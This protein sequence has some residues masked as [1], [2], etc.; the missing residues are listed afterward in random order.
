MF[1]F[2]RSSSV[3]FVQGALV[4]AT[5]SLG[6]RVVG[7]LRDRVLASQFGAG[8][9]LDI[10]YAAFRIPDMFYALIVAGALSGSFIPIFLRYWR[11]G[12]ENTEAWRFT[13]TILHVLGG[14][15]AALSLI[16]M[17][18]A[19]HLVSFVAPGFSL[20]KQEQVAEFMRVLYLAQMLLCLSAVFGNVLQ[21]T[22]RFFLF[23]FA[24]I[25]YNVGIIVGALVFVRWV[26]ALGL[27]L[28]VVFGALQH[29]GVTW[30]GATHVGYRRVEGARFNADT[31][32]VL[33]H[34]FPR[35]AAIG[36]AQLQTW[37]LMVLASL[38]ATGSVAVFSLA[39]NI[40]SFPVG[41]IGISYGVAVFPFLSIQADGHD[42]DAFRRTI[43]QSVRH[44]LF[45]LI[46]ATLV[47]LLLRA[48]IVR[49]LLGAGTFDWTETILVADT[50][51]FFAIGFVGQSLVYVLVRGFFAFRDSLTPLI[52]G[53]VS[54]LVLW[55]SA[56]ALAPTYGVLGLSMPFTIA[57][58]IQSALLWATLRIRVGHLE[59]S[60]IVSDLGKM[61]IA[62]FVS[63]LVMQMSKPLTLLL[64]SLET[65]WG[66]FL[67]ATFVSAIGIAV[68]LVLCFFLRVPEVSE[69]LNSLQRCL[70]SRFKPT[71]SPQETV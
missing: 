20:F 48:Q 40:Q 2:F 1:R 8:E 39:Y 34:F 59:E 30:I 38:L 61:T 53:V 4:L 45:V 49:I 29:L 16:G 18:F 63:A 10:Y 37:S 60:S 55:L 11:E 7:L 35:L 43:S 13:H 15:L 69:L 44:M 6:S 17:I 5:L 32:E 71:E 24:P 62:G 31:K 12:G 68:Y 50:L 52:A 21:A 28:G 41:I 66:V 54:L 70:L 64:A 27:A 67:Q 25:L 56:R 57:V 47:F 36:M 26:G 65:F 58:L 9:T 19:G 33:V 3:S 22:R 23:A 51:A 42:L 46:P 14:K